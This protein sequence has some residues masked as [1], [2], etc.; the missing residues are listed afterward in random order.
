HRRPS[1]AFPEFTFNDEDAEFFRAEV[2]LLEGPQGYDVM[3]LSETQL[4]SD[5]LVQY[6]I[7]M[8]LLHVAPS[9]PIAAE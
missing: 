1:F 8:S 2:H 5:V 3:G 4:I 6:D 9:T 7:H